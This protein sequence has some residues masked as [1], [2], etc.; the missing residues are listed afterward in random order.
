MTHSP[1][2]SRLAVGALTRVE[3]EGGLDIDLV[4]GSLAD[5]RLRIFEPP[6]FFEGFLRG[7]SFS[8]PPDITARICGICPVAYQMSACQAIEA[9]CGVDIDPELRTLRHLLYCGEWIESHALHV[10]L[11]HAPDFLGYESGIAMAADHRAEVERGLRLKQIGNE[12]VEVV[13]GR[14]VHP[15]NVRIGGFWSVPRRDR[16]REMAESLRWACDAAEEV[17]AWTATLPTP[18][19]VLPADVPLVALRHTDEYPMLGDRLVSTTGLDLSPEEYPAWFVEEHVEHSTALHARLRSP[20]D[21]ADELVGYLLGPLARFALNADHLAPRAAAAAS[22]AGLT[23]HE[24]NPFR[25]IVV[26][27]VETLHACEVALAIAERYAPPERACVPV[28]PRAGAGSGWSEA[29]RGMLWHHYELDDEGTIL[30]A[31]I[32]PP[33]SQN[34][35]TIEH[36]LF[37]LIESRLDAARAGHAALDDEAL[38]ALCEQAVRSYDPC[39][40]CATHFLDVRVTRS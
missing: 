9:A 24:R 18:D 5:V 32:V 35:A 3:G 16:V 23:A 38:V 30:E 17:V 7:R 10:H 14:A 22:A 33:T 15:V 11:L 39:I 40:S 2:R 8:E 4:D 20:A 1:R 26:R 28:T 25:S 6:R 37:H 21:G 34:Q 12:I 29:P 13:G 31:R 27:A 36:D 19:H